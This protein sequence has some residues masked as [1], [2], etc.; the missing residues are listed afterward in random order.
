M[1][2]SLCIYRYVYIYI[3]YGAGTNATVQFAGPVLLAPVAAADTESHRY[4]AECSFRLDLPPASIIT[5]TT[6][7]TGSKLAGNPPTIP[8]SAD[9]LG[10]KNYSTRFDERVAGSPPLYFSDQGGSFALARD[11]KNGS[12][13]VRLG[14][15]ACKI[16]LDR[17]IFKVLPYIYRVVESASRVPSPC[18]L[19]WHAGVEADGAG[20]KRPH[21]TSLHLLQT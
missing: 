7:A 17:F 9:F 5:V 16:D 21:T 15:D 2:M 19:L 11:E 10:T 12:N 13:Q 20:P 3:L 6:S 18:F 14:T 1:Y 8:D 4:T